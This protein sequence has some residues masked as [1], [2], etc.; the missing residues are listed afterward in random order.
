MGGGPGSGSGASTGTP[1]PVGPWGNRRNTPQTARGKAVRPIDHRCGRSTRGHRSRPPTCRQLGS[2][3]RWVPEWGDGWASACFQG[4]P[5]GMPRWQQVPACGNRLPCPCLTQSG[6]SLACPHP[7]ASTR[8][9]AM[10]AIPLARSAK[11][12]H[13]YG[14]FVGDAGRVPRDRRC[15]N[16]NGRPS[17]GVPDWFQQAP[18]PGT[19]DTATVEA[20][21]GHAPLC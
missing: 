7:P 13:G 9:W 21:D 10:W 12:M 15:R 3:C 14:S 20:T 11:D 1:G 5:T 2:R 8:V 16:A 18:S 17:V 19:Q 4:R 6:G